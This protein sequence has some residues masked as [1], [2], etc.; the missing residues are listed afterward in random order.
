MIVLLLRSVEVD[1]KGQVRGGGEVGE[2]LL[3][4]Q[5][6]GAE[7]EVLLPG[8]DP[9]D[10]L[11]DL[12]M[13]ERLTTGDRHDRRAT[14]IDRLETLLRREVR[15]QNLRRLLDLSTPAAGEIAAEEGLEHEHERVAM[16]A[17]PP[18]AEDMPNDRDH[19][20]DRNTHATFSRTWP[21][22]RAE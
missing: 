21:T 18:L 2:H 5:G 16:I 22:R 8:D 15:P 4:L 17:T 20:P 7:I 6:V 13:E 12:R 11:L 3:Q 9:G 1:R 14:L 19:L 10:D